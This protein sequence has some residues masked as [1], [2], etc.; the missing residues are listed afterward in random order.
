MA[1][2]TITLKAGREAATGFHHPWIFSGALQP[3]PPEVQHGDLVSVADRNGRIIGTGTY[4]ADASISVR[5]LAFSDVTIDEA[6]LTAQIRAANQRRQLMG[7]GDGTATT[8]Y[9]VVFGEADSLPGLVI[10]RY[11]DV[12]VLQISTAGMDR[13]RDMVIAACHTVFSPRAI[14]ERSDLPV[15][16]G[17][18]LESFTATHVGEVTEPV[19][20]QENGLTLVADVLHGQKTGFYVDQRELRTHVKALAK[21]RAVLNLFSYTGATSAAAPPAFIMSTARL[22]R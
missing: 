2:P 12:L 10:D 20:F 14:V 17:E 16:R 6:W 7:Y 21:D 11:A 5:L 15:R 22:R 1:Y 13:L 8:G 3:I 4:T 19:V 9:R 18:K